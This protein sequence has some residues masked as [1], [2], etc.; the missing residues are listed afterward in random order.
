[1]FEI[2]FSVD[3]CFQPLLSKGSSLVSHTLLFGYKFSAFDSFK[4]NLSLIAKVVQRR[5]L[6]LMKLSKNQSV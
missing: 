2:Y 6:Y 5:L 4:Q 1:M 3:H